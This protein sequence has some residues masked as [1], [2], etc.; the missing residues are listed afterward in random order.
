MPQSAQLVRL[1]VW[2]ARLARFQAKTITVAEFCRR[3]GVSV[4]SFYQWKKRLGHQ[5]ASPEDSTSDRHLPLSPPA[6]ASVRLAN[7]TTDPGP[8]L[9]LPGGASIELDERVRRE[10]LVEILVA[11]IQATQSDKLEE[12]A[13]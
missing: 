6:F 13:R 1:Q 5:V 7:L 11:C 3:E 9:R 2:Q 10:C 12:A 8:V 4:P